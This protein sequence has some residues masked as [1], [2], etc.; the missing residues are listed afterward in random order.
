MNIDE[1]RMTSPE[2][3]NYFNKTTQTVR[4]W[5][6]RFRHHL[7]PS[8]TAGDGRTRYYIHDDLL[9]LALVN[10]LREQGLE[11]DDIDVSLSNGQR[12]SLA[13]PDM[14]LIM[15]QDAQSQVVSYREALR[16]LQAAYEAQEH[17]LNTL[18]NELE[19]L[20]SKSIRLEVALEAECQL[21]SAFIDAE[22]RVQEGI[23]QAEQRAQLAERAYWTQQIEN[24]RIELERTRQLL[25]N[26]EMTTSMTRWEM[27]KQS[28]R[29]KELDEQIGQKSS[30]NKTE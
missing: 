15:Q 18:K 29:V 2:V 14:K 4:N 3:A 16:Q 21:R 6:E 24:L 5:T 12:G 13:E 28:Q 23:Q 7:S 26:A 11:W 30:D 27:I 19:D 20:K 9:V 17:E 8:A 22:R 10:E 25:Q 1:I